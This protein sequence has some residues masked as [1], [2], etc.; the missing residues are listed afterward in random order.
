LCRCFLFLDDLATELD[1]FI[2]DVDGARTRDQSADLLLAFSAEGA[3]VVDS[4]AS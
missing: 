1:T 3:P 4:P 2:A